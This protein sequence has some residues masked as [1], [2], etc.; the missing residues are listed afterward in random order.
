M[1]I[2]SSWST[3]YIRLMPRSGITPYVLGKALLKTLSDCRIKKMQG[4][5]PLWL[6]NLRSTNGLKHTAQFMFP[7]CRWNGKSTIA[8]AFFVALRTKNHVTTTHG[9]KQVLCCQKNSLHQRRLSARERYHMCSRF[10]KAVGGHKRNKNGVKTRRCD[11]P[12]NTPIAFRCRNQ[13]DKI[14]WQLSDLA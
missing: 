5:K 11:Y 4:K 2:W 13:T 10:Y 12:W 9:F 14:Y 7:P 8:C 1:L 6:G 3:C